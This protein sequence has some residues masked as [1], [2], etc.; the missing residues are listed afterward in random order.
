MAA[1]VVAPDTPGDARPTGAQLSIFPGSATPTVFAARTPFWVGCG[2]V[3]VAGAEL[4]GG[5]PEDATR[6]ELIVDGE[7][8]RVEVHDR[9]EGGRKVSQIALATFESGLAPGWHRFGAR[10]YLAGRLV[11][12]SDTSIEFVEP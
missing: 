6:F 12:T 3:P 4:E 9:R 2:F 10:W 7:P 8:A 11:L 1:F 5:S